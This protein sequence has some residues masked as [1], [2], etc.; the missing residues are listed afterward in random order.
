MR[1]PVEEQAV[2]SRLTRE[3]SEPTP[4]QLHLHLF[5]LSMT[6]RSRDRQRAKHHQRTIAKLRSIN[7]YKTNAT[8]KQKQATPEQLAFRDYTEAGMPPAEARKLAGLPPLN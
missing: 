3:P 4:M 6:I 5:T 2:A 8:K 7:A 1:S